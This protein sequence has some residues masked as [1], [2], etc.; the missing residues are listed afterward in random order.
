MSGD[1]CTSLKFPQNKVSSKPSFLSGQ[2]E[3]EKVEELLK[4]AQCSFLNQEVTDN[5]DAHLTQLTNDAALSKL[6]VSEETFNVN[7][8]KNISCLVSAILTE[9]KFPPKVNQ[10]IKN[11]LRGPKI[12][13]EPSVDGI[14]LK[15]SFEPAGNLFVIKAQK[16]G[17]P[18]ALKKEALAG[19]YVTN[20]V[21]QFVP[22]FMYVYGFTQCSQLVED[23]SGREIK[24]WCNPTGLQNSY[25][26]AENV[27]DSKVL[28][29]WAREPTV[30]AVKLCSILLQIFEALKVANK[31]F[32]FV[33][34]DLHTSNVLVRDFEQGSSTYFALPVYNQE[35]HVKGWVLTQHVPYVIDYGRSTF[36]IGDNYFG[37]STAFGLADVYRLLASIALEL[38]TSS[39]EE[40]TYVKEKVDLLD[41]LFQFFKEGSIRDRVKKFSARDAFLARQKHKKKTIQD[42]LNF[43]D[44]IFSEHVLEEKHIKAFEKHGIKVIKPSLDSS[45][46]SCDFEKLVR[47]SF[48]LRNCQDYSNTIQAIEHSKVLKPAK[49]KTLL[50]TMKEV[51]VLP[52]LLSDLEVT[53]MHLNAVK[54]LA[55]ENTESPQSFMKTK[56]AD[57]KVIRKLHTLHELKEK[58]SE[59]SAQLEVVKLVESWQPKSLLKKTITELQQQ[60]TVFKKVYEEQREGF[61]RVQPEFYAKR[62]RDISDIIRAL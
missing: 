16:S 12:I 21:R 7:L 22:N 62:K 37:S 58:L 1:V 11:W 24:S 57:V 17:Q 43:S 41:A 19:F 6:M 36:T 14:V 30:D 40:D 34:G 47:R 32:G 9:H 23:E 25:L 61:M 28:Y 55:A 39:L 35:M 15:A 10:K 5:F 42:F 26:I 20:L 50:K 2:K 56:P 54:T 3:D 27:R 59:A 29:R 13:G 45:V 18:N 8:H 53:Q 49:K 51:D 60:L 46:L 38:T 44:N 33:H 4:T 48:V 31:L 52:L